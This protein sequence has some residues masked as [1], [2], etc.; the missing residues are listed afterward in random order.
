[1]TLDPLESGDI[2]RLAIERAGR[3]SERSLRRIVDLSQ[4]KPLFAEQ[5][6]ATL[7]DG[8]LDTVPASLTGLLS[9]RLDLVGPAKRDVL[10]V[11]SIAGVDVEIGVVEALVAAEARPFLDR[12]LETLERR[13]LIERIGTGALGS[14]TPRS[15]LA[16]RT[17]P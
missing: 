6:L 9:L 5:L 14:R 8:E 15:R 11:A 4:G 7:D 2:A 16:T 10:R 12:H 1:M 3:L 17:R 13:W